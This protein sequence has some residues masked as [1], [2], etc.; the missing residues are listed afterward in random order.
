VRVSF[1]GDGVLG[2]S[3]DGDLG[4]YILPFRKTGDAG[5]DLFN[6]AGYFKAGR[7]RQRGFELILA[8]DYQEVGKVETCCVNAHQYLMFAGLRYLN[9]IDGEFSW[10]APLM[11]AD[12]FH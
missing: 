10:A 12:G 9:V 3:A 8:G 11:R 5:A 6:R 4:Y 1:F 7:E 2:A